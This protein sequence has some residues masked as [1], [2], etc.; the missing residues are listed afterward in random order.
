MADSIWGSGSR[1]SDALYRAPYEFEFMQAVRLLSLDRR[2]SGERLVFGISEAIRFKVH[3]SM[4]FPASPVVD[5]EKKGTDIP[6][7]TVALPGLLGPMRVLPD[8]YT[9]LAIRQQAFGDESFAAFF[10]IFH[11]RLMALYYRAWEKH[12]FVL[13][14]EQAGKERD[15]VTGY[16]LD[17][18]G[19]GTPGLERRLPFP[20]ENLLRYAGLL[21]QR[22]RSA[23]CL[24]AMLHDWLGI[25]VAIE[26]FR[27]RWHALEDE[28]LSELGSGEMS[29]SLGEGAVAGD[30]VW[31][32]QSLIR[33]VLGPLTDEEYFEFLPD[34]AGFRTTTALVRWYLGPAIDFEIQPLFAPEGKPKW[35]A[36]GC[37]TWGDRGEHSTRL[38]WS[39]WLEEGLFPDVKGDAIFAEGEMRDAEGMRWQ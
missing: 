39:S 4:A 38:G 20:E 8:D 32:V 26:Q 37:V 17:L 5:L 29:S 6:T 19:M 1:I 30:M 16:L 27:G 33:I 3:L 34:R 21:A 18:I 35:K 7:V 36:L 13:S 31:N 12:Q 24:R 10:D 14:Q 28:E 15:V 23:E 11:H 25:P 2:Q 22:P 9:E